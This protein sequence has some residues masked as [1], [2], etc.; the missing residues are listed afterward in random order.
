MDQPA[1]MVGIF[2][3]LTNEQHHAHP[4]IG[5]SGLKLLERSPLHYWSAYLDPARERREATPAMKLGTAWHTAVFEAAEFD[6]RYTVIPE[7]LDKRTKEGK[8]LWAEIEASGREPITVETRDQLWAMAGAAHT[9]PAARVLFSQ[10]GHAEASIFWFDADT[11]LHCKILPDWAVHP[12]ALFPHGLIVDGKSAED[13]SPGE[14]GRQAFNLD[15]IMAAAWYVDGYQKAM[16]TKQ[17]PAFVWLVQEKA[18]P[19]ATACYAA[20]DDVL[21]YGRRKYRRLLQVLRSCHVTGHWPGYPTEVAP[22]EVPAWAAK[23][24]QEVVA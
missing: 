13:A 7:G 4:A 14:F 16:G 24:V 1:A 6:R 3:D 15:Y 23:Q 22:V 12:C 5:A 9:H 21:A 10:P 18:K 19:Y 2:A 8:A 20:G 11:G 17:P